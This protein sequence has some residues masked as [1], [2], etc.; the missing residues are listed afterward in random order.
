MLFGLFIAMVIPSTALAD[1]GTGGASAPPSPSPTGGAVAPSDPV[2]PIDDQHEC[3]AD[4][5]EVNLNCPSETGTTPYGAHAVPKTFKARSFA[6]AARK[7]LRLQSSLDFTLNYNYTDIFSLKLK[8]GGPGMR[9][10]VATV[11]VYL[12]DTPGAGPFPNTY[13]IRVVR[14]CHGK[15]RVSASIREPVRYL[16]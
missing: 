16:H 5:P 9:Q 11:Y 8:K 12:Y 4:P 1:N 13:D 15:Y 10:Y 7:G 3:S 14:K 2:Q 6:A